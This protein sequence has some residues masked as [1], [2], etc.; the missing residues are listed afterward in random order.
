VRLALRATAAPTTDDATHCSQRHKGLRLTR[1]E[2]VAAAG[3]LAAACATGRSG[4]RRARIAIVG[5]GLSGMAAA[6]ELQK[7]GMRAQVY[8]AARRTG[9]RVFTTRGLLFPGAVAELGGEFIDSNHSALLQ[10]CNELGLEL[11][12]LSKDQPALCKETYFF[13]G[14]HHSQGELIDSLRPFAGRIRSDGD[15]CTSPEAG[16]AQAARAAFDRMSIA[17]YLDLVGVGGWTRALLDAAFITEYGADPGDQSALNFLLLFDRDENAGLVDLYG[18][19]DERFRVAGG[20]DQVVDTIHRRLPL[21]VLLDHRLVALSDRGR[22]LSLAFARSEGSTVE[23]EA[24]FAIITIPFTTL[25]DVELNVTLLEPQRMAIRELMLGH[26]TK[27]LLGYPDAVWR[28]LGYS[29]NIFTDEPFQSGWDHSRMQR[30]SGAGFTC[31]LGGTTADEAG[32]DSA[33][34]N[35]QRFAPGLARAF[36]GAGTRVH[37]KCSMFHWPTYPF[38]RGGYSYYRPGQATAFG[39]SEGLGGKQLFFAGEHCSV[40]FQGFMNGAAETG[41]AA[42]RAVAAAVD[43]D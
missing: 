11:H 25:R 31:L 10:L 14:A 32:R 3:G 23:V 1:R 38:T 5:A 41:I 39:G 42:A 19:S 22:G 6:F 28:A 35:A 4:S 36:P 17:E 21:P 16:A 37:L 12:D 26:S 9:G 43:H 15:L 8:E 34:E 2:F 27:V 40:E 29:G 18:D 33:A 30:L 7:L 24:D 13:G 20:N